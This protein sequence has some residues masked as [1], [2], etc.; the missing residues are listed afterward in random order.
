MA[1]VLLKLAYGYNTSDKKDSLALVKIVQD[2]MD[3][4]SVAS[5][6]GWLVDSFP[7]RKSRLHVFHDR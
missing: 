3:G 7:L 5:E 1:I 6:P 2:A 4:F